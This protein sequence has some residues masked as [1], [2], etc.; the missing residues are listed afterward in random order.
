M[1]TFLFYYYSKKLTPGRRFIYKKKIYI[2]KIYYINV[3]L[4]MHYK[5]NSPHGLKIIE[6]NISI[7]LIIVIYC[8][9]FSSI[10]CYQLILNKINVGN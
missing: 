10:L 4:K 9:L 1:V 6:I 8:L 3:K 7:H 5:M 2:R